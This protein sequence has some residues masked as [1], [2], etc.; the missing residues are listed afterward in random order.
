[1]N[2]KMKKNFG[3]I[4]AALLAAALTALLLSS[5]SA[6]G[7]QLCTVTSGGTTYT[8]YGHADGIGR[9]E[10]SGAEGTAEIRISR[11]IHVGEPYTSDDGENYGL[12]LCDVDGD[13]DEDV[14]VC[15]SRREGAEKYLFFLCG[16]EGKYTENTLLSALRSPVFGQGDGTVTA[17]ERVREEDAMQTPGA[18]PMYRI[19][20]IT[21]TFAPDGKGGYFCSGAEEISFFS[22]GNIYCLTLYEPAAEGDTPDDKEF[23]LVIAEEKWIPAENIEKYGIEPLE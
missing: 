12:I 11:R 20:K 14:L 7:G 2:L 8:V 13:G 17:T 4:A 22:E 15:T 1:M 21:R 9:I 18:P 6:G 10:I 23:G 5:C 3:K 19:R 16:G